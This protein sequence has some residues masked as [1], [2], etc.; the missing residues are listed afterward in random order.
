MAPEQDREAFERANLGT[1]EI[2]VLRLWHLSKSGPGTP[3][4]V[5]PRL[6]TWMTLCQL[7]LSIA[8]RSDWYGRPLQRETSCLLSSLHRLL[9]FSV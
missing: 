8:G 9:V 7:R 5:F 6:E 2:S 3:R 4:N 1:A